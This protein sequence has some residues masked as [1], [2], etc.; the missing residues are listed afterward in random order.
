MKDLTGSSLAANYTWTFTTTAPPPPADTTPP[1]TTASP[2]GGLYNA[3][4]NVTLTASEQAVIYYTTDGTTPTTSSSVYST[5]LN[6]AA[7]T[8]LKFFAKD[9]AGNSEGVKTETYTIDTT[10]PTLISMT[11]ANAAVGIAVT[12]AI[13]VVFSEA[14][15]PASITGSTFTLTGPGNAAIAGTVS[16]TGATATFTPANGLSYSAT[17]TVTVTTG[18]KDAA[19][20]PLASATYW[21]FTTMAAT[22]TTPPTVTLIG[23]GNNATNV[24]INTVIKATFSEALNSTTIQSPATAF[25]VGGVAGSVAYDAAT[26]T[27]TFTPSA[28]LLY[29]TVYSAAVS[30]GVKDL[31]G[32]AL[33]GNYSWSFTTTAAPDTTPPAT[34]ATPAGGLFNAAQLVTLSSDETATIYYTVDGSTPTTGSPSLANSGTINVSATTTL[35]FFGIDA[36]GNAEGPVHSQT[37]TIDSVA[38]VTTAAPV[39]GL[40]N[41]AKSVT[42]TTSET[43]TIYYTIDGTTPTTSSSVYSTPLNIAATT[44]LK[45]FAKDAAGNSETVK[46]ETYTIDTAAPTTTPSPVGGTYSSSQNVTLTPNETATIYYTI[47]GTTPTTSSSV[48]STP[49]NI[50][51]T[52]TLKF[53]AK[54]AAGNSETPKTATYTITAGLCL[55]I[56]AGVSPNRIVS[57]VNGNDATADGTCT[58]PYKTIT[59]A[60]ATMT[61]GTVWAAPGTYNS[62][63]G[64]TFPITVPAGVALIGDEAT[65]GAGTTST[66]IQ[67]H[68]AVPTTS[69]YATVLGSQGAKLA[70]FKLANA[71]YTVLGFGVYSSGADFSVA[72]NTFDSTT[73]GGITFQNAGN[74]LVEKNV[75][76][77]GSYGV[78]SF[79]TGTATI[80]DNSF[81]AG[82][83][84]IDN[85]GNSIIQRNAFTNSGLV[86]IQV[87]R[88]APRILNN[89][90]T[91]NAYGSSGAISAQYDSTPIIRGNTFTLGGAPAVKTADTGRA[92]PR[93]R[94]GP[95]FKL[96][97]RDQHDRHTT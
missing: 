21:S 93:Y 18:V 97:L 47:D 80:Q 68:G 55:Q 72:N 64:E 91:S 58:N 11:P 22:D 31:A 61:T 37:Y 63:L 23:P 16:P 9:G 3:A 36:A 57:A 67:G 26:N 95:W 29:S 51:A 33:A 94:R 92:R 65:K 76:K 5:P 10:A 35:K 70:G 71:A 45:F 77:A 73:Y 2:A 39:G 48:Y 52:T 1:T 86:A 42:L 34:T 81:P 24:L 59:A 53:F 25:T 17:Y 40:Y 85:T 43:A 90:F 12:P 87:Q 83:L 14:M 74:P 20:N 4:Q 38:P 82:S 13:T 7:T 89:T 6:I 30:T 69:F 66:F 75:F 78:Y 41:S 44:T 8:T 27:A 50:A 56:P 79:C 46:T 28:P 49:L 19:G 84:P 32:N 54:D 60:L 96:V 62:S 15:D 88:G